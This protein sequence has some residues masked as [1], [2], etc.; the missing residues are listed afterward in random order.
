MVFHC[1]FFLLP[2]LSLIL[3]CSEDEAFTWQRTEVVEPVS[4]QWQEVWPPDSI[5]NRFFTGVQAAKRRA[6]QL[7]EVSWLPLREIP[8][9]YGKYVAGQEYKG[10]PYSLAV[11]SDTHVG[12]QV[13]LYTY[14][15]SIANPYSLIYT[16]D[17]RDSPYNGSDC[18]PYYGSTCSN[19][20]MYALGIDEPYY[21][22]MI[23]SIPGMVK[24]KEQEPKDI[25]I[26]DILLKKGHVVMVYDISR[27]SEGSITEVSIFE[28]TTYL[29]KDTWIRAMSIDDFCKY[30]KDG[31]YSIYRYTR[32]EEN[33]RY[34]PCILAPLEDE[35]DYTRVFY[36]DLCPTKG[37]GSSY[38]EGESVIVTDLNGNYSLMELLK[39]GEL[40]D[41]KVITN[42]NVVFKSLPFG[43]YKAR[44]TNYDKS[45]TSAWTRFEVINAEVSGSKGKDIR[46]NYSSANAEPVYVVLC[47][48]RHN[49]GSYY[50]VE[51][52]KKHGMT[53]NIKSDGYR[54]SHFKV[55]FKGEYGVVS[56]VIRRF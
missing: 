38:L 16:E 2:L 4:L 11:V 50:H 30:Y 44:L 19:S 47:D 37:D 40:Y 1:K 54:N 10:V 46:I 31:Q 23:P 26:C 49:P 33:N 27:D 55:Y 15:T 35:P 29:K 34:S 36:M 22:Y 14:A 12:T 43:Q 5:S 51:E 17:L 39:D 48:S 28:T 7:A 53:I 21:T 3:A 42:P 9:R 13:S 56:T 6:R 52:E 32:L 24:P 8:S 41:T 20:V 18:A 45:G 25:E